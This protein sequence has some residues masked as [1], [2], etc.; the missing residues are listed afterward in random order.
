MN[1]FGE[2]FAPIVF[3]LFKENKVWCHLLYA[4]KVML[5]SSCPKVPL[6]SFS[7]IVLKEILLDQKDDLDIML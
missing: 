1:K 7:Q 3:C 6:K 5:Q 2:S 4:N